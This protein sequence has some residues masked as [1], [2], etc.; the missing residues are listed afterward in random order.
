MLARLTIGLVTAA[1]LTFA[2]VAEARPAASVAAALS[3]GYEEPEAP[4]A[5]SS[6]TTTTTTTVETVESTPDPEPVSEPATTTVVVRTVEGPQPAPAPPPPPQRS[7]RGMGLMITGFSMFT[8]IYL[9]TAF[10]GAAVIDNC[11]SSKSYDCRYL[12]QSLMIPVIGPFMATRELDTLTGRAALGFFVG[13]GQIAGLAMGIAGAVRL[14]RSRRGAINAAG[15]R[16]SR[17]GDLRLGTA[18]S[19]YGGGLQLT[20]RF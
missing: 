6:S 17:R 15:V 7:N 16:L 8:A 11:S 2:G 19:T 20:G 13:G 12:G 9:V 18:S 5:T 10:S 1:S 4:P 14:S 3:P